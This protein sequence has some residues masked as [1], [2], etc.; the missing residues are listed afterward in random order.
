[1]AGLEYIFLEHVSIRSNEPIASEIQSNGGGQ[2]SYFFIPS[3]V[4]ASVNWWELWHFNLCT[5]QDNSL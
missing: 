4:F 1:M 3:D 5:L 2:R